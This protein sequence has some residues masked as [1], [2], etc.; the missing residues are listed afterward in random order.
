MN[1][2]VNSNRLQRHWG[3]HEQPCPIKIVISILKFRDYY[4]DLFLTIRNLILS[5]I[6][7]ACNNALVR[8]DFLGKRVD[9]S[10]KK[11]VGKKINYCLS[12]IIYSKKSLSSKETSQI[13]KKKEHNVLSDYL[14]DL[15]FAKGEG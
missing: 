13:Q 6:L 1:D 3:L 9:I 10:K 14:G 5:I 2:V 11:Q 7:C 4:N 15:F 8:P 12:I